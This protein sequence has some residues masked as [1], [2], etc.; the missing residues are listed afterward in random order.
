[1]SDHGPGF[2][3]VNIVDT[4]SR[5]RRMRRTDLA[6]HVLPP[7]VQ[8]GGEPV[9]TAAA[10]RDIRGCRRPAMRERVLVMHLQ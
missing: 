8:L 9:V 1:M 7:E 6:V 3:S 4:A 2:A 5:P 10:Q